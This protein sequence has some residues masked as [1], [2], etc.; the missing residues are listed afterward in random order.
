MA[1]TLLST[2]QIKFRRNQQ[3][4]FADL[5]FTAQPTELVA[6][7]GANG[8][9]KST[10]LKILA[11]LLEP[12]SGTV[13]CGPCIYLGHRQGLAAGLTPQQN[14][15]ALVALRTA[16]PAATIPAALLS[17]GITQEVPC[18]QLSA[19]QRQRVALAQLLCVPAPVWLL[20]EPLATLDKAGQQL[21]TEL[22]TAHLAAGNVAIL[23][24]HNHAALPPP[25]QT[26]ALGE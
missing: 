15:A 9:G 24:N 1:A 7:T 26:I 11:G 21:F 12:D 20:D 13:D 10:L 8:S 14:L 4:L 5:S 3:L 16:N 18:K 19:G 2:T 25:S 6:I 17:C 22:L 23:S